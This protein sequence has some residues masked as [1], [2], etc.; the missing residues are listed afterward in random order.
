VK[1]SNILDLVAS[2]KGASIT[3]PTFVSSSFYKPVDDIGVMIG[4]FY[5]V[6]EEVPGGRKEGGRKEG[7]KEGRKRAEQ[8]RRGGGT[9]F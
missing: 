9:G 8:G 3:L 2:I 5:G 6:R 1:V 7:R 4:K